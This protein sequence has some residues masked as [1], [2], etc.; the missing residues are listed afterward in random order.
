[1]LRE[2]DLKLTYDSDQD[3]IL[4]DFYIPALSAASNYWRMSAYFSASSLFVASAGFTKLLENNGHVRLI[5]GNELSDSDYKAIQDGYNA[6]ETIE[7]LIDNLGNAISEISSDLFHKRIGALSKLIE[8][9][10]LDIKIAHRKAGIFHDKIGV[11]W[12]QNEDAIAFI[13][14]TNESSAAFLKSRNSE[15]ITAY[16]SWETT[17]S[18]YFDFCV[19]RF[20]NL[21]NGISDETVVYDFQDAD[22]ASIVKVINA[23]VRQVS[24]ASEE[25]LNDEEKKKQFQNGPVIPEKLGD[26][27]FSL[28]EHQ[29]K[30]LNNWRT[31]EARGILAL[32][33]GAGKT[34]TA[35]YGATQLFGRVKPL[36]IVIGVPYQNLA[37]QWCDVLGL[38]NFF[39]VRAYK[40][41]ALWRDQL[42]KLIQDLNL[43]TASIGVCVVVNNTLKSD[44][45]QFTLR[46]LSSTAQLF[47]IGDECHHYSSKKLNSVLPE[48]ARLR[49]G[50]SATPFHYINDDANARLKGYFGDVVSEYSLKDALDDDVLTQYEYHIIPVELTDDEAEEYSELSYQIGQRFKSSKSEEDEYLGNLLRKRSRLLSSASNKLIELRL[51]LRSLEPAPYSLFYCGDGNVEFPELADDLDVQADGVRQIEA[52]TSILSEEGWSPSRFTAQETAVERKL[53]LQDFGSGNINSLVA[54][55]CLDEGIDIPACERAFFLASSSNPRQFIQR[56]GR[57][58]R[59]SPA[60]E[61]SIIYDFFVFVS[62]GSN[63]S[64]FETR[65]VKRE[66]ERVIEFSSSAINRMVCYSKLRPILQEYGLEGYL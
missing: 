20:E 50:L 21:W 51:L 48:N 3:D 10:R 25:T 41:K 30:A 23:N 16:R 36:F 12:D 22:R 14:S 47:F 53:I 35:I 33:T 5:L 46:M 58:L 15:S 37:D 6:R 34:I 9:G 64:D 19:K 52:T 32:A 18:T 40:S 13:G 2:Q 4:R 28:N 11:F 65:L 17:Q 66:L 63:S 44:D 42:E 27:E 56:R 49:L 45:F 60:K 7:S 57:I 55:K 62:R 38:F 39:P 59:K 24:A 31:N 61:K 1:M 8:S 29:R 54:I 26:N 43:G